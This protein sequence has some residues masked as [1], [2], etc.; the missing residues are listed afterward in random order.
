MITGAANGE[1]E[2]LE[3]LNISSF[4]LSRRQRPGKFMAARWEAE[5]S[6]KSRCKTLSA[7][8]YEK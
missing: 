4:H 5:A 8:Q 2:S 1:D 7:W 3:E 6:G